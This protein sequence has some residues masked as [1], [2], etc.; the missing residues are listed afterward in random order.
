MMFRQAN[1][2]P[3]ITIH[4]LPIIPPQVDIDDL[5]DNGKLLT[6]NNINR[7]KSI[8]AGHQ[9]TQYKASRYKKCSFKDQSNYG[10]LYSN[11]IPYAIY[12]GKKH[13]KLLGTGAFGRIKLAQN[14]ITGEWVAYKIQII[15]DRINSSL[16]KESRVHDE[17]QHIQSIHTSH[18]PPHP[19]IS[20]K[21][22]ENQCNFIMAFAHGIPLPRIAASA[23]YTQ[24]NPGFWLKLI[25]SILEATHQ[26]HDSHRKIHRDLKPDNIIFNPENTNATLVDFGFAINMSIGSRSANAPLAGSP[27]YLDYPQRDGFKKRHHNEPHDY[28]YE[29]HQ[30]SDL[31]SLAISIANILKLHIMP[32]DVSDFDP[33]NNYISKPGH[34]LFDNNTH[35]QDKKLLQNLVSHLHKITDHDKNKRP[36][37]IEAIDYFKML[38]KQ[39]HSE[40]NKE[41]IITLHAGDLIKLSKD[42]QLKLA[43]QLSKDA[44]IWKICLI[45]SLKRDDKTYFTLRRLFEA[46]EL[47]V[48]SYVLTHHNKSALIQGAAEVIVKRENITL[49]D[50]NIHHLHSDY[51]HPHNTDQF[52][53]L[54]DEPVV[55]RHNC[56]LQ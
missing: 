16:S 31:F 44:A 34:P 8:L 24:K 3:S 49:A 27:I 11:N 47:P 4:P 1:N 26:L 10:I 33:M 22:D 6:E 41:K 14:L 20:H 17:Y 29:Y 36:T 25:I 35:I 23:R 54:V 51:F 42:E 32:K 56:L 28:S 39:S 13:R 19:H 48:C 18:V 53:A 46:V 45:D 12:K 5:G 30:Q 37:L 7:I 38:L 9:P 21:K 40:K 52:N 15:G 55:P 50:I 2:K 43:Q